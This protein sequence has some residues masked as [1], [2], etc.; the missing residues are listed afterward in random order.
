MSITCIITY[1]IEPTKKEQ[2]I[3]YASGWA[4]TIPRCGA[5]L[6]GYYAPHEGSTSTAY[7]IYNI[8]DLATYEQYRANLRDDV[9][10]KRN[11]AFA[12]QEQFIRQET[13]L[14]VKRVP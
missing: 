5:D 8:K 10:G 9:D 13:R 7:G 3:E 1:D 4:E 11:F 12:Q 14:F 2:F 6:I